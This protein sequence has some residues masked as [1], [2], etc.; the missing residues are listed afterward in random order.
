MLTCWSSVVGV[1]DDTL[2]TLL[3]KKLD[4]GQDNTGLHREG[5]V[6]A[7]K[8]FEVRKT[9]LENPFKSLLQQFVYPTVCT[10]QFEATKY[11][12][13]IMLLNIVF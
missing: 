13:Y 10:F 6:T 7:S 8:G 11:D 3:M 9:Q 2:N 12:I 5:R 4:N 1:S